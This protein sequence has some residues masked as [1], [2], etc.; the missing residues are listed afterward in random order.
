[1]QAV[2]EAV[3]QCCAAGNGIGVTV[4]G[5]DAAGG[6][7]QNGLAVAAIAK[8]GIKIEAAVGGGE[9]GDGFAQQHRQVKCLLLG[10][11]RGHQRLPPVSSGGRLPRRRLGRP[12]VLARP[13]ASASR[14]R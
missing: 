3:M 11:R 7:L 10:K 6:G 4:N 1:M 9:C 8:C 5:H 13:R 14:V 2:I 12:S